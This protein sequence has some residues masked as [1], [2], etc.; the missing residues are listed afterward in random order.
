[1][2]HL[3]SAGESAKSSFSNR[4]ASVNR[5]G[6]ALQKAFFSVMTAIALFYQKKT[7][8][9]WAPLKSTAWERAA[10]TVVPRE[11]SVVDGDARVEGPAL[12]FDVVVVGVEPL[13][14][15]RV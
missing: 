10:R 12:G 5:I 2:A 14:V 9:A 8:P 15:V 3:R 11:R 6:V 4:F 7:A 1:M 13:R